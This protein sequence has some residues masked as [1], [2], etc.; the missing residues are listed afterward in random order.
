MCN[1]EPHKWGEGNITITLR[2]T[3]LRLKD[4]LLLGTKI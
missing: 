2:Y 1:I 3:A 4:S